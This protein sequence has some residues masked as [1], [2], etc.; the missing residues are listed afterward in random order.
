MRRHLTLHQCL[1]GCGMISSVLY[2][3]V[4][5]LGARRYTGYH[6]RD[7]EFSELTAQGSPT[8]PFMVALNVLPYDVLVAASGAGIWAS[9]RSAGSVRQQRAARLSAAGL[10]GYAA[11]GVA[12]G[13]IFP[14]AVRGTKGTL[15]NL[16][17]IPATAVMSLF[18]L[19][20]MG[21]AAT[22]RGTW[23]RMYTYGTMATLLV[24]GVLTSLQGGRL[25]TNQPTPWMGIT[26]R[27]NIY[28]SMLW[29]AVLPAALWRVQA[30]HR[31]SALSHL[32]RMR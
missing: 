14:M 23:F 22:L 27:V 9:G 15:R 1:L 2:I 11:A 28:A 24:F 18:L 25:A 29:L 10:I 30:S 32:R 3:V 7:Q 12:G 20:A 8:R 16:M 19:V 5:V 17:H 21:F 4:D 6:Y 13:G 26:E 31:P